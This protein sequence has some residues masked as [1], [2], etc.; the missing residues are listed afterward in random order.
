MKTLG[1]RW[2]PDSARMSDET[3]VQ[4]LELSQK[5]QSKSAREHALKRFQSHLWHMSPPKLVSISLKY[6]VKDIFEY[7]FNRLIRLHMNDLD[8][9]VLTVPVWMTLAM[10]KERLD[11]HRRIVACEPPPMVHSERCRN[12]KTCNDDWRQVWWNGMGRFLLDGRN[13]L[14]F[15]DAMRLFQEF[16]YGS[17]FRDCWKQML[18]FCKQGKAFAHERKL[19]N[20][21]CQELASRLIKE[22]AFDGVCT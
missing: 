15:D 20:N 13:S 3:V 14:S 16:E 10:V 18:D 4:L 5:F 8:S 22:P 2:R 12:Q 9:N 17:V 21:T 6:Q 7:A 1:I 19:I 11:L